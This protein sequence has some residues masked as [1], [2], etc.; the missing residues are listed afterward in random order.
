M[1]RD[2]VDDKADMVQLL[3]DNL[4]AHLSDLDPLLALAWAHVPPDERPGI[5][6]AAL[7]AFV[8]HVFADN[9]SPD[10]AAKAAAFFV[11]SLEQTT[12]TLAEAYARAKA[13]NHVH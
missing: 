8:A 10:V 11:E 12:R 1:T 3:A 7:E 13:G 5:V 4:I 6:F 9:G 2:R